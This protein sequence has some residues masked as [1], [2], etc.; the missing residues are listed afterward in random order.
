M[1]QCAL[2][3]CEKGE[4]LVDRGGWA[5]TQLEA[6]EQK[7]LSPGAFLRPANAVDPVREQVHGER[8]GVAKRGLVPIAVDEHCPVTEMG[9]SC[10]QDLE[11]R[12]KSSEV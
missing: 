3:K 11:Q 4:F 12:P 9:R 8:K 5:E 7:V 10:H 6:F 2:W 1:P